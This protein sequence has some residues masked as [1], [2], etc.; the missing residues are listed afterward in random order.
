MIPTESDG[1]FRMGGLIPGAYKVYA[2]EDIQEG[3]QYDPDLLKKYESS[4]KSVRLAE[5]AQE[6]VD[7]LVIPSTA[8]QGN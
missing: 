3:E 2:W 7:L 4:A 1:R 8:R 5:R 6:V